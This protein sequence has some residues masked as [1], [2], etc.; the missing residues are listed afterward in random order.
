[1]NAYSV[2][3]CLSS[4]GLTIRAGAPAGHKV[5]AGVL[6][7]GQS[8]GRSTFQGTVTILLI[9]TGVGTG[10]QTHVKSSPVNRREAVR[11]EVFA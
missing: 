2:H 9:N 11:A 4:I 6:R 3:L 1:M 10:N 8:A 7:S 5:H